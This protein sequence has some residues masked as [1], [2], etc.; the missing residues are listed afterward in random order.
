MA[1]NAVAGGSAGDRDTGMGMGGMWVD[2]SAS[3]F[4]VKANTLWHTHWRHSHW[5]HTRFGMMTEIHED[6]PMWD[7]PHVSPLVTGQVPR[8]HRGAAETSRGSER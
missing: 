6:V 4:L 8:N 5:R 7:V 1:Q 2:L 3:V